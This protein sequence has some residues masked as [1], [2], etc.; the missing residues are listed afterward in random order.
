MSKP[1]IQIKCS[2]T[3]KDKSV[4]WDLASM[5]NEDLIAYLRTN[6]KA[7]LTIRA[8]YGSADGFH[9]QNVNEA[10]PILKFTVVRDV[11]KD[12]TYML[13]DTEKSGKG[14][15]SIWCSGSTDTES[16]IADLQHL[17]NTFS[18]A[19]FIA[20]SFERTVLKTVTSAEFVALVISAISQGTGNIE[21][22]CFKKTFA[23]EILDDK[24]VCFVY[25]GLRYTIILDKLYKA[26]K[27]SMKFKDVNYN[28]YVSSKGEN[29]VLYLSVTGDITLAGTLSRFDHHEPVLIS[30]PETTAD[31]SL[32]SLELA[33]KSYL[34]ARIQD[35]TAQN[36]ALTEEAHT[37]RATTDNVSKRA[38]EGKLGADTDL[39]RLKVE[40]QTQQNELLQ[41]QLQ[42]NITAS[43][44][45]AVEKAVAAK[46]HE[47]SAKDHELSALSADIAFTKTAL[48]KSEDELRRKTNDVNMLIEANNSAK[49]DL[50]AVQAAQVAPAPRTDSRKRRP[51]K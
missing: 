42:L 32:V 18:V 41:L 1:K 49:R 35:L 16:K 9:F 26:L 38:V 25:G 31:P 33:A 14:S 13:K 19:Q 47:L 28:M 29:I 24:Y 5:K 34:I 27:R 22:N 7:D 11:G 15:S 17:K 39:N 43:K 4:S 48:A 50:A 45:D 36:V 30:V 21:I 20:K 3:G 8:T 44:L 6:F 12:L 51:K 40:K 2:E 46:D 37:L 10:D 23:I